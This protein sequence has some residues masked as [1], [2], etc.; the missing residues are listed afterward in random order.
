[1]KRSV[2]IANSRNFSNNGLL[3]K[4]RNLRSKTLSTLTKDLYDDTNKPKQFNNSDYNS[5]VSNV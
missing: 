2:T 5:D 3:T 1:M 4:N